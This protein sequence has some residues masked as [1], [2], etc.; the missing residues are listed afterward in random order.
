MKLNYCFWVRVWR[1]KQD[2]IVQ[3]RANFF[4]IAGSL[5]LIGYGGPGPFFIF[6]YYICALKDYDASIITEYIKWLVINWK[7]KEHNF[8]D[9]HLD[10][11]LSPD[12]GHPK[13]SVI[14]I[15]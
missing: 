5:V 3:K 9:V 7:A 14:V 13:R 6:Y 10:L 2:R 8:Q 12:H 15:N 1:N 4:V 11:S